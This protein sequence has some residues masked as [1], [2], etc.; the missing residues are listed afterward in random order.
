MIGT[1]VSHYKIVEK[2]GEGGMGEVYLAEDTKLRRKVALKFLAGD[3][4][5]DEERKQRFVQEARAAAAIEHPHVAAVY[6]IDETDDRTFIAM[7]YVRGQSLR[8]AIEGKKLDLRKSLELATQVAEALS[9]AHER[10]VIHRDLKPQ[11]VLVSEQGYA[12]VIDFGLAK[13]L[14]PL[15]DSSEEDTETMLKTREG[16][17]VGTVAYMSPEQARGQPVEA[18]SDIFSFGVLLHEMLSGE[19][20]FLKGGSLETLNAIVHDSAEPLKL[21]SGETPS[22]LQRII[23]K[24][25]AKDPADRYQSIKDLA[26][27]LRELRRE[28]ESGERPVTK[29]QKSSHV[30]RWGWVAAIAIGIAT[31]VYVAV[32]KT[33]RPPPGIGSSGRPAIAVMYFENNTGDEEIRWLSKGLPSMLLTDLAQTP[34]LDVV[35]SQRIQEVLGQLGEQDLESID[36]SLVTEIARRAGAGAVVVGSIFKA[37]DEIRIDVQVEDVESGRVLSAESVRGGDV[38]PL[39]DDLTGRIRSSLELTDRPTGSPIAEVTTASLEAYRLYT[40]GLDARVAFRQAD[41]AR[42]FEQAVEE[43]PSFAMAYFELSSMPPGVRT[44]E[45]REHYR[46]KVLENLDRLPERDRLYVEANFAW[47]DG[48]PEKGAELFETLIDLYPDEDRAYGGLAAL[49]ASAFNQPEKAMAIRERAVNAL[50]HSARLHFSYGL[51]LLWANRF[52]EAIREFEAY[53]KLKPNEANPY[54]CLGEACMISGQPEK[55]LENYGRAL[56]VD[57]SFHFAYNGRAW[58]HGMLGRYEDA[59]REAAKF[60]ELMQADDQV[61]QSWRFAYPAHFM[62]AFILSRIGR[63][64][65]AEEQVRQGISQAIEERDVERQIAIYLLSAL[66]AI[67]RADYRSARESV[68]RTE[69]LL[70]EVSERLGPANLPEQQTAVPMLADLLAGAAEAHSGNVDAARRYLD[71]QTEIHDADNV[72][73]NWFHHALRGEIALAEGNL[74]EAESAFSAGQPEIKMWLNMMSPGPGVFANNLPFRD[75]PARVKKA[76]GDLQGAL[77]IYRDLNTPGLSSKWTSWFEPRYVLETA[78]LLDETGDK[79]SARTEYE[80]FL[81]YWKDADPDLPEVQEAKKYVGK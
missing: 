69:P 43:D 15:T 16:R 2:I 29:G 44:T 58:A 20:P 70:S 9:L 8:Q 26:I 37:G 36:K 17:V 11:N 32:N 71:S 66:L 18:A 53:A 1:S 59:Y 78:R 76:Q 67:E 22:E 62:E 50:A 31:A 55:A 65:E 57:P 12:K 74:A 79:N 27:D 68:G 40:E 30:G 33:D 46:Q 49:Y 38:F 21:P 52:S 13:L 41:A 80:R 81:E 25:T 45:S 10:G 63:Y 56:E 61:I 6:D 51:N 75:G 72:I 48:H 23:K 34:G 5:R 39:V 24:A 42:L 77:E 73:G 64:R 28:V 4:T 14:E 3:L 60:N 7:E 35:S 54:D 47:D 19:N